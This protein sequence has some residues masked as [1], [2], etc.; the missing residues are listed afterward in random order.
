MYYLEVVKMTLDSINA[1]KNANN[2]KICLL[3]AKHNIIK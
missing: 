3:Y 2:T 1:L